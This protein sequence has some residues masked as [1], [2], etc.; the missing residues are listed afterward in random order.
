MTPAGDRELRVPLTQHSFDGVMAPRSLAPVAGG[1]GS[2]C[3]H[4]QNALILV[5]C[6]LVVSYPLWLVLRHPSVE[7]RPGLPMAAMP[8]RF[9]EQGKLYPDQLTALVG[10][11][12]FDSH[13]QSLPPS[14]GP[15]HRIVSLEQQF[16]AGTRVI[17]PGQMVTMDWDQVRL[18]L[19]VN[20]DHVITEARYG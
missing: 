8:L 15:N 13:H 17:E 20:D 3:V 14:A 11:V 2:V 12:L 7:E 19:I 1:G 16:P 10:A 9:D 6:V 18:N 5:L 4:L